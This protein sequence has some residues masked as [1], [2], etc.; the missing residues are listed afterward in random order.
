MRHAGHAQTMSDAM[1]DATSDARPVVL[2]DGGCPLCRREIDHYRRLRD[3]DAVRW[4]DITC[5]D[6]LEQR[7][8]VGVEAA[9]ARFHVR[10]SGGRW[11]TGAQAFVELWSVLKRY[12]WLARLVRGLRLTAVLEWGYVRFAE[13][14]LR[15]RCRDGACAAD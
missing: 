6:R 14:R 9:M 2:F 8:G 12:R 10:D 4:V 15:Q 1:S 7:F 13:R 11:H 5:D 3:A